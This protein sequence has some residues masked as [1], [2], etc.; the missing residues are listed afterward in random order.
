MDTTFLNNSINILLIC[1]TVITVILIIVW[2]STR[3]NITI[4]KE[5]VKIIDT[6]P[7]DVLNT[8]I[9]GID[10]WLKN[11]LRAVM[12]DNV[13]NLFGMMNGIDPIVRQTLL[14]AV[15]DEISQRISINGFTKIFSVQANLEA[16]LKSRKQAIMSKVSAYESNINTDNVSRCIDNVLDFIQH[17]FAMRTIMACEKKIIVYQQYA[18]QSK[19]VK[20]LLNKN[21]K[22]LE[23]LR[24]L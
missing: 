11:K 4:T 13:D 3:K 14:L 1:A 6:F 15:L 7:Y 24:Q 21:L 2:L 19:R 20:Y 9:P 8:Q 10:D 5:G 22:Y 12:L 17:E 16:W 18:K 23:E